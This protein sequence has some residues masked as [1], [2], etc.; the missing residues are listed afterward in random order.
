MSQPQP[1]TSTCSNANAERL[2]ALGNTFHVKGQY[3]QAYQK[4]SEA[5]KE[6]P[7][8][9]ILFANRAASALGMKQYLDAVSDAEKATD[10]DPKYAKAWG[11][12]GT[13]CQALG[14]WK[15]A[16]TCF[17]EALACLPP[18]EGLTPQDKVLKAQFEEGLKKAE[19]CENR[20]IPQPKG[21]PIGSVDAENFP[22]K[23]A[24]S[25]ES[26]VIAKQDVASS[27]FVIMSAYRDFSSGI[28]KM[29]KTVL[30]K[31][32]GQNALSG[33]TGALVDI[34]NGIL[35]DR[36][37]FHIDIPD[38]FDRYNNQ[39]LL[40]SAQT[41]AWEKAGPKLVQQEALKRLKTSGWDA[42]RPALSTTIRAWLMRSFVQ[43]AVTQVSTP[44][45]YRHVLDVLDWGNRVWKDVPRDDRGTIFDLTF[46]RG[47]RR[48]YLNAIWES[49]GDKSPEKAYGLNDIAKVAQ[50]TIKETDA[51]PPIPGSELDPGFISSFYIYPKADALAILGWY[52]MQ[53]AQAAEDIDSKSE[54]C[55]KAA[56]HYMQAASMLPQDEENHAYYLKVALEA[57][58]WSGAPLK[59]TLPLCAKIREAI[60]K[61][62]K[63]WEYSSMAKQRDISLRQ[64]LA[65]ETEFRTKVERGEVSE[66][67]PAC[68]E[69]MDVKRGA[70]KTK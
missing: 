35:R 56:K 58:W 42:V 17:T 22:W 3:K 40:E 31:V 14:S 38:F 27:A 21:V 43:S 8:N 47:V 54:N 39:I 13:G 61:M 34:S 12:Q 30:K 11:R 20:P 64:A 53:V 59:V 52:H 28:E 4:Y 23:R 19:A 29:K 32:N 5:I 63:I 7:K 6:D 25:M 46:I 41:Q 2:K 69:G 45:F 10:L 33:M 9:A 65:F 67:I 48:L 70:T 51:N 66:W 1:S 60:P 44:E 37:V 26:E 24:L 50:E 36:R 57:F 15:K 49:Y 55:M 16:I 68:P 18:D 62:K